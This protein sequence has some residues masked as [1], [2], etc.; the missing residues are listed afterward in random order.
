MREAYEGLAELK[1][2]LDELVE[3][4][5][6]EYEV[7]DA[8][9]CFELVPRLETISGKIRQADATQTIQK[10]FEGPELSETWLLLKL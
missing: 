7:A 1:E 9:R 3:K 10:I 6:Q 4:Q 2:T 5:R 8:K